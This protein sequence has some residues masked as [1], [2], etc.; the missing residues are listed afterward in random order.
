M[1]ANRERELVELGLHG[2]DPLELDRERA[3]PVAQRGFHS[4][5][6]RCRC[7]GSG[8]GLAVWQRDST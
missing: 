3:L 5:Q 7:I 4:P 1:V 2:R 6:G 8:G